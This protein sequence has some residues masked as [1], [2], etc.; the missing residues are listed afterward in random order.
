[1]KTTFMFHNGT[2]QLVLIPENERDEKYLALFAEKD[3]RLTVE[4]KAS[5]KLGIVITSEKGETKNE[6]IFKSEPVPFKLHGFEFIGIGPADANKTQPDNNNKERVQDV[7]DKN[8]ANVGDIP[9]FSSDYK[10]YTGV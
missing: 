10:G 5:T 2:S 4:I 6:K 3:S 9:A 7:C 1:M 8:R